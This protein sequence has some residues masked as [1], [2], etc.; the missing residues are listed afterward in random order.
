M[1]FTFAFEKLLNHK[2]TLEDIARRDYMNAKAKVDQAMAEMDGMYKQIDDSRLRAGE[3]SI[4]GGAHGPALSQ[5]DDFIK[6]QRVRIEQYR[7]KVRE[8][9]VE[10]ERLQQILLEAA[11]EKKTLEKLKE[12]R[13]DEYKLRRK[14]LELKAMDEL[15]TTRFKRAED[16]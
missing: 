4:E 13:F 5:I 7:L 6:G 9:M 10:V 8:L 1:K 16:I 15:T 2:R 14:K 12:R 11:K 3:L